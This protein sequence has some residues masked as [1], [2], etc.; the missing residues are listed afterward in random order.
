MEATAED[1]KFRSRSTTIVNPGWRAVFARKEDAEKDETEANKGT[2][3]F[4]EGE[5]IP[6]T[7]YGTAQ[8]KTMPKPLYTEATLLAAMETCGR[9]IT[10]EKAKEAMK[11]WRPAV[12]TSP[13]RRQK[14]R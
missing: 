10:D 14:R 1:M 12:G 2:A 8:R 9:N 7:G 6:V 5:Q 4:A 13:M 3:R 11:L